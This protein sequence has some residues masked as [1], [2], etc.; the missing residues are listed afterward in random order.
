[1][2]KKR[3]GKKKWGVGGKK[4]GVKKSVGE[5]KEKIIQNT[6]TTGFSFY[7]K[8]GYNYVH[9]CTFFKIFKWEGVCGGWRGLWVIGWA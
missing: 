2:G 4:V 1:M 9:I 3:V 8:V 5:K 7:K 6:K